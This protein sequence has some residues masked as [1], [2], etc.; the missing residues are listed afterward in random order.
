MSK[1]VEGITPSNSERF[2]VRKVQAMWAKASNIEAGSYLGGIAGSL[3]TLG[4]GV[5]S[6]D[7]VIFTG[8]TIVSLAELGATNVIAKRA[9]KNRIRIENVMDRHDVPKPKLLMET[10]F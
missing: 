1:I 3:L 10:N 5:A 2:T 9:E 8:S 4:A 7:V 6:G